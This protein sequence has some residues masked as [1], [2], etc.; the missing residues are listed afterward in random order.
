MNTRF[1]D[2]VS[3]AVMSLALGLQG[4]SGGDSHVK[5][6]SSPADTTTVAAI[7]SGTAVKGVVANADC[8]VTAADQVTVLYTTVGNVAPCT[9]A[10]GD[11]EI[12]L[13]TAPT[14]PVILE[15]LPRSTTTMKCDFPAG[16]GS[17]DF[18]DDI[19]LGSGFSLRAIVPSVAELTEVNITPWSE[20]AAARAIAQTTT[21][22]SLVAAAVETAQ[23]EVAAILNNLLGLEGTA[24]AFGSDLLSISPTDLSDPAVATSTSETKKGSLLSLAS[25][26]LFNFVDSST[27]ATIE[28]V[29][30]G[31]SSAFED[32]EL[33]VNDTATG[34]VVGDQ[35]LDLADI[36]VSIATTA[37]NLPTSVATSINTLLGT[38]TTLTSVA[39]DATSFAELK[40]AVTNANQDPT[41]PQPPAA[42]GV[43]DIDKSKQMALDIDNVLAAG[44][45]VFSEGES[46]ATA[47]LQD[48][49]VI[50]ENSG[51]NELEKLENLF[52]LI[53]AANV[54]IGAESNTN[55]VSGC[56]V[57]ADTS[58]TC[59]LEQAAAL[60]DNDETD[61]D[62]GSGDLVYTF[63]TN[64]LTADDVVIG[65][66]KYS[67][68]QVGIS[69]VVN[70]L[71][72]ASID[73]GNDDSTDISLGA[74]STV[75]G[76]MS[77]SILSSLVVDAVDVAI[78]ITGQYSF[79]GDINVARNLAV[80]DT[81]LSSF[82]MNGS[83]TVLRANDSITSN[84]NESVAT[85]LKFNSS[86]NGST[87]PTF[88][89]DAPEE[90]TTNF[91]TVSDVV[92]QVEQDIVYNK[93]SFDSA[94]AVD[95]ASTEA[96]LVLLIT[97]TR[98]S[99]SLSDAKLRL[100]LLGDTSVMTLAGSVV[101]TDGVETYTLSNGQAKVVVVV[102]EDSFTGTL[103]VGTSNTGTIS[104][105]GIV[106]ITNGGAFQLAAWAGN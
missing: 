68:T 79:A 57:V 106:S 87:V 101:L 50:L 80:R 95:S 44:V 24:D 100:S 81:I 73:L 40:E 103:M 3:L 93:S 88:D 14:G 6:I 39:A 26:S 16:C 52:D 75:T 70:R 86:L 37:T 36:L 21:G 4:C 97:G 29:I 94:G 13:T 38:G 82:D 23:L 18:G 55:L 77:N 35:G 19:A 22:G 54:M 91:F 43:T 65:S 60:V 31:L 102:E 96:R 58:I 48:L 15:L 105:T 92:F 69:D 104:E 30:A 7:L 27:F 20:I 32:G 84:L 78:T 45:L 99:F 66:D 9:D 5:E 51:A 17:V 71:D 46:S 85:R 89:G 34:I 28:A 61:L 33:N 74:G 63:A 62:V 49:G 98:D 25:A 67:L 42:A 8:Q 59:T 12:E 1:Q 76:V 2:L 41:Q 56:T 10:N 83:F 53:E 72:E 90:T 64:T 47:V 11:Y